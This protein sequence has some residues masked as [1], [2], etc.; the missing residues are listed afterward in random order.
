MIHFTNRRTDTRLHH[1]RSPTTHRWQ[2]ANHGDYLIRRCVAECYT[3]CRASLSDL[4]D[5]NLISRSLAISV[6]MAG[7]EGLMAAQQGASRAF[8]KSICPGALRFTRAVLSRQPIL[9]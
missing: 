8:V 7:H 4:R 2:H 6:S 1:E 9:G 5:A 3:L